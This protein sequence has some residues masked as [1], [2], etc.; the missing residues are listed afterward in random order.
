ML[1]E[2]ENATGN[3]KYSYTFK[4]ENLLRFFFIK[5]CL[6]MIKYLKKNLAIKDARNFHNI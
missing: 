6:E 2:R 5:L 1:N 3:I 4:N